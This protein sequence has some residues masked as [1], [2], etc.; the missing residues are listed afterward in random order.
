MWKGCTCLIE[1]Y[2]HKV[3]CT[4]SFSVIIDDVAILLREFQ[5]EKPAFTVEGLWYNNG[6]GNFSLG[7]KVVNHVTNRALGIMSY[8]LSSMQFVVSHPC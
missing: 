1:S 8:Q 3:I 4:S 7:D 2:K 5:D 6:H